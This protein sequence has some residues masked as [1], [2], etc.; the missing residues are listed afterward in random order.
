MDKSEKYFVGRENVWAK[1]QKQEVAC[2]FQEPQLHVHTV[3]TVGELSAGWGEG[4][5]STAQLSAGGSG[6]VWREVYTYFAADR[7]GLEPQWRAVDDHQELQ[8]TC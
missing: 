7:T 2:V 1:P 6:G 3:H 5:M 4:K 8:S